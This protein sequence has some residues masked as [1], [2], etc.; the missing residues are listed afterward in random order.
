M[1]DLERYLKS[2]YRDPEFQYREVMRRRGATSAWGWSSGLFALVGLCLL[3]VNLL[4]WS[5]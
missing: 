1:N 2:E 5:P 3:V 4:Y